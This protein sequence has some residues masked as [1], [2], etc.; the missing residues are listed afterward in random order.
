VRAAAGAKAKPRII[1]SSPLVTIAAHHSA[2]VRAKVTKIGRALLKR[3]RRVHAIVRV[4]SVSPLGRTTT[5]SFNVVLRS[6]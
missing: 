1:A 3:G 5:H 6:K 4:T 2:K